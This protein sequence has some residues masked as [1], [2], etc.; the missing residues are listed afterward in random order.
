MTQHPISTEISIAPNGEVRFGER[1]LRGRKETHLD[2]A[3][4]Q[5]ETAHLLLLAASCDETRQAA[6][7][8]ADSACRHLRRALDTATANE[9]DAA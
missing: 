9:C 6:L 5:L 3:G 1:I 2:V 4:A 7:K 8:M